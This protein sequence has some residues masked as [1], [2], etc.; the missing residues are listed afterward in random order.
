MTGMVAAGTVVTARSGWPAGV[1]VPL[2]RFVGRE[3]EL[4]EVTRQ[5]VAHRLVTLVG[6][7][8]VG[9]TRL[10]LEVAATASDGFADGAVVVDLSA[11]ADPGLVPGALAR[12]LGVEER[13]G[14]GLDQRLLR[15]LRG[16]HRLVVLDNCEHLRA[17]CAGLAASVLGWCPGVAILATSRESLGVA[18]EVT[19][20]VPSLSFPWPDHPPGVEDLGTFEAVALF[21][22]RARAAC[23]G[24]RIGPAEAAVITSICFRLDGIPLALELAAARAGV[25]SLGEI[26]DRLADRFGLLARP[27]AGPARQQTLRASVEWSHQLLA[28]PER[29]LFRRLAVFTGGWSLDS[30]EPVCGGPPLAEDQVAVLLAAL[31]DKSLVHAEQTPA[32]SRYRLL[33]VIRVFADEWLAASGEA[34]QVRARHGDYFAGLAEASVPVLLG[35]GQARTAHRLDEETEN[36]RAARRWCDEDAARTA[37]GLRLAAGLWEYWHIRGH[38]AEGTAWLEEAL[39]RVG[40]PKNVRASALNGLGVLVSLQGD[41]QRGA[42]LFTESVTLYQEAG[43][44]RGQARAWANLGNSRVIAG[45]HADAGKAFERALALAWES[46]DRWNLAYTLFLS[47]RGESLAGDQARA[48]ARVAE[49]VELFGELGDHRA[50]GYAL[51]VQGGCLLR[52]GQPGDA[53]LTAR[54]GMAPFE[55]LPER[56]GLLYGAVLLAEACAALGDW[57]RAAMLLGALDTLCERTGAQPYPHQQASLDLLE[58]RAR[59]ELGPALQGARQ[60]GRVIGRGDQITAALWSAASQ[61]SDPRTGLGLPLTRREHQIA[62]LIAEGLTNRQIATRLVIAE[63]TVDTHVGRILA[64]LGCTNRAQA[65]AIITATAAAATAAALP[66]RPGSPAA[67]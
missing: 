40:G 6:A 32:G 41:H 43:D 59:Q 47:G 36:L 7:G 25:L 13:A 67:R 64:K 53:L 63:R 22:D 48:Q 61:G 65:A 50:V 44:V 58:T 27:G 5:V 31:V 56:F 30:A 42:E 15:V 4:A 11:V 35:P 28:E 62:V 57:P 38:L 60:A 14:A 8:G 3:R 55:A 23:P 49:S 45:G 19:W 33:E 10:A 37:V 17:A 46:G 34:E 1:P 54:A 9:K 21:L 29:V 18:G 2:T 52:D 66:G 39:A 24:L 16:Q 20:R 12:G 26:A 51:V